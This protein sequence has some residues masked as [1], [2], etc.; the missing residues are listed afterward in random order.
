MASSPDPNAFLPL[1]HLAYQVLLSLA[2]G[3]AHGY[4]IA[5]EVERRCAPEM[6]PSTGS[7][8]LAIGRLDANGLIREV[9]A[10]GRRTI[11]RLT[12]LG[13]RVAEAEA[14][15]LQSLVE[16]A[17]ARDLVREPGSDR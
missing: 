13:R 10:E 7:L 17:A 4:A 16:V 14:A 8:Y 5:R 11:Y 6:R 15:R 3:E 9:G 1:P 12:A 2:A